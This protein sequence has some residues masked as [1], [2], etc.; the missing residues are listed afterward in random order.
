[1]KLP[2]IEDNEW[3]TPTQGYILEC[4]RCGLRHSLDTAAFAKGKRLDLRKVEV[5][6]RVRRVARRK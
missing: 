4:C 2:Q 6:F 3:I 1:M 5:R